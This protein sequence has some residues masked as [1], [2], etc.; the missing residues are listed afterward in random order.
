MVNKQIFNGF[1]SNKI[2]DLNSSRYQ[3]VACRALSIRL[4]GHYL[5]LFGHFCAHSSS[6]THTVAAYQEN[7]TTNS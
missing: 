3:K 6:F 7:S 4:F 2:K 1:S 5:H